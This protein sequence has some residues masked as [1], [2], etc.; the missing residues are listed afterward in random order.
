VVTPV[1]I[2]ADRRCALVPP[3][4][5]QPCYEAVG[6]IDKHWIWYE[7]DVGVALQHLGVLIGRHARRRLW[8]AI[9]RW[10][11]AHHR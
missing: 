6:A 3:A 4:A 11:E 1:L 9:L 7:G 8:P 10:I 2:V 5:I